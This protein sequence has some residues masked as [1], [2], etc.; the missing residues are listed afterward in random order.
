MTLF[1]YAL[2]L[3]AAFGSLATTAHAAPMSYDCDTAAGRFSELK[4][5]QSGPAYRISGRVAANEL[6][7]DKRWVPVANV[8]IKSADNQSLAMLRLTAPT[9]KA[10]LE[11][12]LSITKAGNDTTQTL[13]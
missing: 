2:P 9:R 11:I 5:V 12:L 13:G 7:V 4:Q 6:A 10:P 8:T 1:K 3:V